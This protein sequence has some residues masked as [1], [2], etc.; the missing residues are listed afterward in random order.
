M[1]RESRIFEIVSGFN[2]THTIKVKIE[3]ISFWSMERFHYVNSALRSNFM[4]AL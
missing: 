4:E 1:A 2:K 3:E